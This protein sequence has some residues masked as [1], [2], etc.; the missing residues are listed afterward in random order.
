MRSTAATPRASCGGATSWRSA[1]RA[2]G[3]QELADE[4]AALRKP[5]RGAWAINQLDAAIR[6]RL[7]EAGE[8]L[9]S[10]Q[11]RLVAGDGSPDEL[12]AAQGGEREAVQGAL[13]ALESAWQLSAAG[14]ERA[15]QTLHAVALDPEVRELFAKPAADRRPR[16]GGAGGPAGRRAGHQARRAPRVEPRQAGRRAAKA[17]ERLRDAERAAEERDRERREAERAVDQAVEVAEQ[18]QRGLARARAALEKARR[19]ADAAN[20]RV[21]DLRDALG[22]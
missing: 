22:D 7:L 10:E 19:R 11:E 17:R 14:M 20:G 1:A 8:R 5:T 6:D 12:R 2:A 18:A 9:R 4:V 13:A 21:E 16:G 3:Q 15:R